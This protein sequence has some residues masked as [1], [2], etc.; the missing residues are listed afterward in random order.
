MASKEDKLK[1]E[2]E[3]KRLEEERLR[4]EAER[5][6]M[7]KHQRE[8]RLSKAGH[9]DTSSRVDSES[10]T[11]T[12]KKRIRSPSEKEKGWEKKSKRTDEEDEDKEDSTVCLGKDPLTNLGLILRKLRNWSRIPGVVKMVRKN[13]AE[14]LER[15]MDEVQEQ[16]VKARE[17]RVIL[18]TRVEERGK[19][20]IE[21]LREV[22]REELKDKMESVQPRS[23]CSYADA[24]ARNEI[25]KVTGLKGPVLPP[26]KL[27]VIR[28][29]K[30]E[31]EEVK[32]KLKELVKPS[33]IGLK[34]KRLNMI[35]NGVIIESESEE[36]LKKLMENEDLKKAGMSVGL[37]TRKN[38]VVMVYDVNA[39]LKDQ[40]IKEEIFARNMQGSDIQEEEFTEEFKIRH[41]YA[42]KSA[43]K[44]DSRRNHL[45]AECSVRVRNWLRR[46]GKVFIEWES[47]RIKDYVD[48]ARCY[49]CQ[50]Y[51][52][53]AK[54]CKSKEPS[55]SWC[56]GE[57]EFKDCKKNKQ[58]DVKCV[59]CTRDGK[60]DVK[61][62]SS[63]RKCPVYEKAVK[64]QNEQIDY[65]L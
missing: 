45:V 39:K 16:I 12:R 14:G 59:N 2:E 4:I 61:H 37:P 28:H 27:V 24:A 34:V 65:G 9:S 63:W 52:H 23:R 40:E 60:K 44:G 20:M 11:E 25:P 64:R 47:C 50:R 7:E 42:E 21:S 5:E 53:V 1:M 30:K 56:A 15:I 54:F 33:D 48:V 31:S 29:D 22:V 38:P 19:I 32:R 17:E 35:K 55:C 10:E 46:K 41:K 57:H 26:P 36:G 13:Y 58:E 43:G 51:G 49:K 62:P 3:R 18:E 6:F 8:R